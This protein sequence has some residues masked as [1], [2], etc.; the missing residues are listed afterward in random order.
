VVVAH[1]VRGAIHA[2]AQERFALFG[3]TLIATDDDELAAQV[4]EDVVRPT[5]ALREVAEAT[6]AALGGG[7]ALD[8]NE[9]HAELRERVRQELLPWCEGCGSHHVAPMLWRYATVKAGVRLTS[10]RRYVL[11][12]PGRSPAASE[13]VERFLHFY[14]PATALDFAD[15]AGVARSQAERIWGKVQGELREV[16]IGRRPA[17]LASGDLDDLESPPDA[18]GIRLI[19]PGDPYLQRPNRPLLAPDSQVRARLFRPIGSPGAV[20]ADGRLAGLWRA[21]TRGRK[22]EIAVEPLRRLAKSGLEAE[23]ERIATLRGASEPVLVIA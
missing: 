2:V 4:G 9:L 1:L 6:W 21:R 8:K 15:W 12:K 7:R 17:W 13:A 18:T 14:G 20:L 23:A 16:A 5:A 10:E 22:A 3:R 19:P 11:G